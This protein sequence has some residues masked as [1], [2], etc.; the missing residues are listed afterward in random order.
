MPCTQWKVPPELEVY[1]DNGP[2]VRFFLQQDGQAIRGRAVYWKR[3]RE[4]VGNVI[5]KVVGNHFRVRALWTYSGVSSIGVYQAEIRD[6][7]YLRDGYTWDEYG[8]TE[9]VPWRAVQPLRCD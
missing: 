9:S 5:G 7:G 4:I 3:S 8:P 6:N 1:Q 2:I